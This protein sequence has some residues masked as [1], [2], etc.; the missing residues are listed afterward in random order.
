MTVPLV[1]AAAVPMRIWPLS[2]LKPS[3]PM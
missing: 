1:I 3:F 2:L